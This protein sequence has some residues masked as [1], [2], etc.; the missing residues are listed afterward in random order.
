MFRC[1]KKPKGK[2]TFVVP[3]VEMLKTGFSEIEIDIFNAINL[4]RDSV[5]I[6]KCISNL[7][8]S[9]IS[10]H[11]N[12]FMI[13]ER[14]VT[15]DGFPTRLAQTKDLCSNDWMGEIL[16]RGYTTANGV[17]KGWLKSITHRAIIESENP[18]FF[19]CS[20]AYDKKRKMYVTLLFM[21]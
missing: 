17:V 4:H 12:L 7:K 16:A 15:H 5:G 20:V 8:L 11:H 13:R 9:N 10:Y 6:K 18:I 14:K 2:E 1:F 3:E 19:G 21:D